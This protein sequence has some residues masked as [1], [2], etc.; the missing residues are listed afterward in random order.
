ME[1]PHFPGNP[2]RYSKI[3]LQATISRDGIPIRFTKTVDNQDLLKVSDGVSLSYGP[4]SGVGI[5][6]RVLSDLGEGSVEAGLASVSNA[7]HY[8]DYGN[9]IPGDIDPV[10]KEYIYPFYGSEEAWLA[11]EEE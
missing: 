7:I 3:T 1:L 9:V 10:Y 6:L 2:E 8:M 11:R 4:G 5:S